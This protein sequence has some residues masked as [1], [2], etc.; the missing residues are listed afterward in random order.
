MTR[1]PN[2]APIRPVRITKTAVILGIPPITS[3]TF[4][5]I[6]VVTDLGIKLVTS[7][8]S[9]CIHFANTAEESIATTEPDRTLTR[10]S[11]ACFLST[12]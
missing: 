3:E 12:L 8:I 6:G 2:I 7:L 9:K 10:I 5:A 11:T 4:I 1:G